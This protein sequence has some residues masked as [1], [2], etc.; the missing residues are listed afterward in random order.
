MKFI[1]IGA[2]PEFFVLDPK[3]QPYPATKLA[4]G[5]KDDPILIESLGPGFYEQRDNLSFEGNIPPASTKEEFIKNISSLRN[6]FANKVGNFEYS[7][8]NN[9][10]EYFVKRYLNTAEGMEFGCSSVVSSWDSHHSR[11][12]ERPT[13]NLRKVPFR[14]AGFHVHI[15]YI[16]PIISSREEMAICIGRLFD[17]FVT[18]PSQKLKPE[19][20]RIRTYG[21]WG[22][23]RVKSYGV[24]CRTLSSYF[25]QTE[26]LSWVWDQIMKIQDF[27]NKVDKED[28]LT[29]T[30]NNHF[31]GDSISD[32]EYIFYTIFERFKNKEIFK[33][34]NEIKQL[35][36]TEEYKKRHENYNKY[37]SAGN[38]YTNSRS[39]TVSET[40]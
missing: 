16:D 5:T 2:D 22:M 20:E 38:Y 33:E 3:G 19:P 6:Y 26:H 8:S 27:V 36:E 34:F 32:I 28:L 35:Y 39:Y 11:L 10:V 13:P 25:T 24:E 17:L 29:I 23:I 30:A 18:I 9:G 15:G 7:L 14:V 40:F 12:Q 31:P 21:R 1:T 37:R 4:K